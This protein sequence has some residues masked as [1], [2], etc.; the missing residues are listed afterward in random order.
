MRGVGV[1]RDD[2]RRIPV[3]KNGIQSR[4]SHIVNEKTIADSQITVQQFMMPEHANLQ[5]NVHG[6]IVMKLVDEAGAL[7]AIR[8]AQRLVV[9]VTIDSIMFLSPVRVGDVMNLT[10]RLIR[11]GT[12]SMEVEVRVVAENPMTGEETHTNSAFAVYVALDDQGHPVPVPRLQLIDD[13][14]RKRAKEAEARQA[15]RLEQRR[16]LKERAH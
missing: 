14:Q 15:H 4:V 12:T 11:V 10:A 5:G 7:C 13:D 3:T 9:T 8:H 16:L 6:G 1:G 2:R